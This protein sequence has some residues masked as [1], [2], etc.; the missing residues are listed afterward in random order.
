[1]V[2]INTKLF[3]PDGPILLPFR[4]P[5][6]RRTRCSDYIVVLLWL[7]VW[8]SGTN[9]IEKMVLDR[10]SRVM[11]KR[12]IYLMYACVGMF[13]FQKAKSLKVLTH[14]L[15]VSEGPLHLSY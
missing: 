11:L 6:L 7:F 9:L 13:H 15:D 8:M 5:L 14:F 10:A 3:I 2:P 4:I 1:M 12:Q